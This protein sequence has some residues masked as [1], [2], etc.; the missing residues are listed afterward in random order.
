MIGSSL[1]LCYPQIG[2]P[3]LFFPRALC[4]ICPLTK[5]IRLVGVAAF[6]SIFSGFGRILISAL[7]HPARLMTSI[8]YLMFPWAH[9][10]HDDVTVS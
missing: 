1:S 10:A 5:H 2:A 7:S 6:M 3:N 8:A 9:N 4:Q